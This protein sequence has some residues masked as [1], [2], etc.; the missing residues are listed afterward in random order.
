MPTQPRCQPCARCWCGITA[1][2]ATG[3]R[4]WFSFPASGVWVFTSNSLRK[5]RTRAPLAGYFLST[6]FFQ[7]AKWNPASIWRT[8]SVWENEQDRKLC[9]V[10]VECCVSLAT[11][12]LRALINRRDVKGP[13]RTRVRHMKRCKEKG[14]QGEVL[15]H[16]TSG[17]GWPPPPKTNTS[18]PGMLDTRGWREEREGRGTQRENKRPEGFAQTRQDHPAAVFYGTNGTA[19]ILGPG[20]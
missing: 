2:K 10:F 4:R 19:S 15:S 9:S 20:D 6:A 11:G 3:R 14:N 1:A 8:R 12:G 17:D 5:M 18:N 13:H 7:A 16:P